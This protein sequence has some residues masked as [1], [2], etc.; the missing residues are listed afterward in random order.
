[1][2]YASVASFDASTLARRGCQKTLAA[3]LGVVLVW[4]IGI[5]VILAAPGTAVR[6]IHWANGHML[7]DRL[8]P[9]FASRFN[10]AGFRTPAG[11]SVEVVPMLANF[12]NT[13]VEQSPA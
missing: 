13:P 2:L 5:G 12:L 1:M 10:A 11:S 9:T 8:L 3:F 6:V 7:E 4:A